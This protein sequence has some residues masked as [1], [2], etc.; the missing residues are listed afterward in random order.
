MSLKMGLQD[1]MRLLR[2]CKFSGMFRIRLHPWCTAGIDKLLVQSDA[3]DCFEKVGST[4]Y[5]LTTCVAERLESIGLDWQ[6][7]KRSF[8]LFLLSFVGYNVGSRVKSREQI[9]G[10]HLNRPTAVG[11]IRMLGWCTLLGDE[12]VSALALSWSGV[13]RKGWG[14]DGCKEQDVL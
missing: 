6:L 7:L 11:A 14:L 3:A 2:Y 8:L 10:F 9:I 4:M 1:L 13:G 5:G 12:L